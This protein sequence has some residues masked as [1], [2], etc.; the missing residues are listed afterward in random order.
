MG[1]RFKFI[2]D[3]FIDQ[4]TGFYYSSQ[5]AG[6]PASN[7]KQAFRSRVWRS[8]G[9]FLV[10]Q[11]N[12]QLLINDGSDKLITLSNNEYLSGA[13]LAT[14]L[15]TKLNAASTNFTVSY[16]SITNK[17]T[18]S[19]TSTFA[20]K[21]TSGQTNAFD[22]FGYS[23]LVDD[24]GLS[25]YESDEARI[26][27]PSEWFKFDFAISRNPKAVILLDD[28]EDGIKIQPST[29]IKIQGNTADSWNSPEEIDLPFGQENITKINMDGIFSKA[30]RWVKLNIED[31]TNPLGRQQ[32]GKIYVGDVFELESSNVQRELPQTSSDLS[33]TEQ[34]INGEEYSDI[35]PSF[36]KFESIMIEY[37]NKNDVDL[38][39]SV[40]KKFKK[41]TPFF[42]SID[43]EATVTNDVNEWT[44]YVKFTNEPEFQ[45][46]AP[47]IWNIRMALKEV[48]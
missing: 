30:Y 22:L 11:S 1:N 37:C 5:D 47:N 12:N 21:W 10:N 24:T 38:V 23:E 31:K 7:V 27:Y 45:T 26:C 43:S 48:I 28:I 44:K 8:N 19:R 41:H 18:V 40:Y 13:L 14:E 29:T 46:V 25:S 4:A 33:S 6:Y 16:S 15:Q 39:K 36:D 17:F 20:I 32:L 2:T 35:R 3:N 34:S 42:V 9:Y